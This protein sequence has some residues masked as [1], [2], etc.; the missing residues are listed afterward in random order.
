MWVV[1]LTGGVASGKTTV[2]Q[3]LKEEGAILLDA[4]Q[5]ARELVAPHTPTWAELIT[6][7][8]TDIIDEQGAV[9]RKKLADLAFSD[10]HR[11]RRLNEI[12]HPAIKKEIGRR[13]KEIEGKDSE[14]IVVVDAALLVETGDY[15][16]MDQLNVVTSTRAQQIERLRRRDGATQDQG[17]R[18]LAAQM[19]TEEKVKLADYVIHNDGPL[20]ETRKRAREIFQELRRKAGEGRPGSTQAPS[21]KALKHSTK[22]ER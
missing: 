14:A 12:L 21:L 16:E 9:L 22:E 8:G 18:I 20:E 5:I 15:R 6:A 4:D 7:F 3:I 2:A 11:R 10:P 19:P 17:Q 1:G 13:L